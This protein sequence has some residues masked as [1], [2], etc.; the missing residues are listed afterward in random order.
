MPTS[1]DG[2]LLGHLA[3]HMVYLLKL[4]TAAKVDIIIIVV[5]VVTVT[6]VIVPGCC[7][8]AGVCVAPPSCLFIAPA[9]CCLLL[10]LC[11]WHFCCVSLFWMIIVFAMH[12][13][14]GTADDN[15]A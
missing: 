3:E 6:V 10:R 5:G 14:G 2:T 1:Y 8:C 13:L 7:R 12:C 4:A 11:C 9:G 15:A